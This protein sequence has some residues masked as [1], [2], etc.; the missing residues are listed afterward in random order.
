M[1]VADNQRVPLLSRTIEVVVPRATW[2]FAFKFAW[3]LA[4]GTGVWRVNPLDPV[5]GARRTPPGAA[6]CF[7]S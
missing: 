1:G 6:G 7:P 5:R 3:L 4:A 2:A